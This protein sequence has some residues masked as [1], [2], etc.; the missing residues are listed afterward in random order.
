MPDIASLLSNKYILWVGFNL[1]VMLMLAI[2]LGL[3][4]KS[5]KEI[6][7]KEAF[8]WSGIWI[9][10]A[11]VFNVGIYYW[12][13]SEV[14]VQFFTGYVIERSLSIDN[15]FVFLLIFTYFQVP[16]RFQYKVLI[17]GILGAL[18]LRGVF[19]LLGTLLIAK[20]HWIIYLFG[21]FL[22]ITG[23]K[24][25]F[26]KDKKIDPEK[27]PM[28]RLFRKFLPITSGYDDGKFFLRK[29]GKLF[30]SPLLVVLIVIESTDIVFAV[31][32]IPAIFAITLDPFIVYT[33]NVFA[34][35]GLRALYFAMAGMMKLFYYLKYALGMILAFVGVKML[36]SGFLEIPTPIALGAIGGIFAVSI[37][38]SLLIPH[39]G[40]ESKSEVAEQV[41]SAKD[42][43]RG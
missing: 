23:I 43:L 22:V 29:N 34:I 40:E 4:H 15:I 35:L 38:M 18:V 33:S 5:L 9:V 36:V 21:A 12:R 32:S 37:V 39:K 42:K 31:D 27:N 7:V 19:I 10:V 14:A 1:L 2:D 16:G 6:T 30:G 11:L 25:G 41:A 17:W 3:I 26:G 28:L 20:F 24:M 13:G 8:V